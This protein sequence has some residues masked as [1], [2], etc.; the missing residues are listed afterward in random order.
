MLDFGGGMPFFGYGPKLSD[1]I[2][3]P[4]LPMSSSPNRESPETKRSGQAGRIF[5]SVEVG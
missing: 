5:G 3:P 4:M 1:R 2:L